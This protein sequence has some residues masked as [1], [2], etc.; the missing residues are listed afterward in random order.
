MPLI[1]HLYEQCQ[2]VF[3]KG[4]AEKINFCSGRAR[5]LASSLANARRVILLHSPRPVL[6]RLSP[7]SAMAEKV[8]QVEPAAVS[9]SKR[10]DQRL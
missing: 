7:L 10:A 4:T 1:I 2:E 3:Y 8:C 5:Q 6:A 9:I